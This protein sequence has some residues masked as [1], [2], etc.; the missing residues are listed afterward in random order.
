[1]RRLRASRDAYAQA[2]T[3]FDAVL[4]PV[5]A[6]VTPRVGDLGPQHP[7]EQLFARLVEHV[8]F[9]PVNNAAGSPAIALPLAVGRDGLPI[10]MH[11]MGRHGD[12]RTLL[13]LAFE[14]EAAVPF[15]RAGGDG[16]AR[17]R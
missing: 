13:E 4:T 10:G 15:R 7:F 12:E 8:A 2:L 3:G 11:L 5:V 6:G 16:T 1:V 17:D 9:T 14:L